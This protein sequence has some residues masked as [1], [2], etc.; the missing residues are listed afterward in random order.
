[1]E[2]VKRLLPDIVEDAVIKGILTYKQG[3]ASAAKHY[4]TYRKKKVYGEDNN[5]NVGLTITHISDEV[6]DGA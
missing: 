4:L 1:M 2:V 3:W 6:V 5:A